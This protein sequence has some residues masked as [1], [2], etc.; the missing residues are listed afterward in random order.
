M[1]TEAKVGLRSMETCA[2]QRCQNSVMPGVFWC[3]FSLM[4]R[5]HVLSSLSLQFVSHKY[6]CPTQQ[7]NQE[8]HK[9]YLCSSE[10]LIVT[11]PS[12]CLIKK[13]WLRILRGEIWFKN[14]KQQKNWDN[15]LHRI[16]TFTRYFTDT[17]K[18]WY[19]AWVREMKNWHKNF[20]IMSLENSRCWLE[21]NI[22]MFLNKPDW[23]MMT[24]FVV[25]NRNQ[26]AFLCDNG[27]E[28]YI[29]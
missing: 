14:M 21:N 13:T 24:G 8:A 15:F 11:K 29:S 18:I 6:Q 1:S 23:W 5:L 28:I 4:Q 2:V 20:T 22:K 17:K 7:T 16:I 19:L 9:V 10:N 27:N 12:L 3:P 26:L 25:Q